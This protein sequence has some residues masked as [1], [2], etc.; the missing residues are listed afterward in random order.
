MALIEVDDDA[1]V[2]S[3]SLLMQLWK[4]ATFSFPSTA[5]FVSQGQTVPL[6]SVPL[7]SGLSSELVTVLTEGILNG[8]VVF[9]ETTLG[10]IAPDQTAAGTRENIMKSTSGIKKWNGKF[11]SN[12]KAKA[13]LTKRSELSENG[14]EEAWRWNE[15]LMT[16]PT[17]FR[18]C[19]NELER[20][21]PLTQSTYLE[22]S[23]AMREE[24]NDNSDSRLSLCDYICIVLRAMPTAT[25]CY[26]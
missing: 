13:E 21:D 22:Q 16:V 18:M 3:E 26:K 20:L 11:Q 5:S 4:D 12:R 17:S 14:V 9:L 10:V 6:G 8:T 15:R 23:Q 1:E 7:N 19:M 24:L 2:R 25:V